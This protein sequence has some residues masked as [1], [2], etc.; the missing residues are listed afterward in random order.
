MLGDLL[1]D[2]LAVSCPLSIVG[3]AVRQLWREV[4]V[5][6]FGLPTVLRFARFRAIGIPLA[7]I[8]L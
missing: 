1:R 3:D 7:L 2:S 8:S 6:P 4:A 5:T